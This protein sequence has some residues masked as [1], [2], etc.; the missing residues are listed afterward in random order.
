[1][2]MCMALWAAQC[3]RT[4]FTRKCPF[5]SPDGASSPLHEPWQ[6]V[7]CSLPLIV[8]DASAEI[9]AVVVVHG[10]QSVLHGATPGNSAPPSALEYS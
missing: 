2:Q 4:Y 5:D 9:N 6:L 8:T 7:Q 10:E 3:I 1:M